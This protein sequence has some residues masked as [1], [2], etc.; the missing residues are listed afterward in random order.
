[1]KPSAA[2]VAPGAESSVEPIRSI[3]LTYNWTH[4]AQDTASEMA[5]SPTPFRLM[6][7]VNGSDSPE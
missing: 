1:M 6:H 4:P 7:P 2:D 5:L 3:E